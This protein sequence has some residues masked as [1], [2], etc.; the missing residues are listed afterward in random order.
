MLPLQGAYRTPASGLTMI[1]DRGAIHGGGGAVPTGTRPTQIHGPG[2]RMGTQALGAP[3]TG[4]A[5]G[6][7]ASP[8]PQGQT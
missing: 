1:T 5:R 3:R 7:V 8:E 2:P 6:R 4:R